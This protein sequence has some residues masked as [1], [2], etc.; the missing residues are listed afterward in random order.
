MGHAAVEDVPDV[1]KILD[2]IEAQIRGSDE[3]GTIVTDKVMA[4]L[5]STAAAL[6]TN[7][8]RAFIDSLTWVVCRCWSLTTRRSASNTSASWCGRR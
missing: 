1:E 8:I 7:G 3:I 5:R 2:R 6:S 4:R